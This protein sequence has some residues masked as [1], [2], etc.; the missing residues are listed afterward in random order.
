MTLR[1][2]RSASTL[3]LWGILLLCL[4]GVVG[5]FLRSRKAPAPVQVSAQSL[6][7]YG[8]APAFLLTDQDGQP[9]DSA[10]LKGKVWIADFI[11]TSC[12]GT[13]P[14]M[15]GK[16]ARLQNRLNRDIQLI[17]VSVDPGRDTPPVLASYARRFKAEAGRWHFLTGDREKIA[18][19]VQQGFG[20]SLAEGGSPQEP[21]I[22]SIRFVLVDGNGVLR[23]FY[24]STD[25]QALEQLVHDAN[26]LG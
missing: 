12:A 10:R 4:A 13:C 16:M 3:V 9:F 19:L 15:S 23:G 26:V 24:D 6:L 8:T 17:S 11:F 21:V 22:H 20:L 25:P 2:R 14:E 18:A 7:R 5:G 1:K